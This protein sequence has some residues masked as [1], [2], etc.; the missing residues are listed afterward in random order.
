M[1]P[2]SRARPLRS[3]KTRRAVS[4]SNNQLMEALTRIQRKRWQPAPLGTARQRFMWSACLAMGT[5]LAA[6]TTKATVL[7]AARTG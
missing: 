5:R 7:T 3:K 4:S 1:L 6:I 2:V